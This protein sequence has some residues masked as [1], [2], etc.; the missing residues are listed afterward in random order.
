MA[1][2][3]FVHQNFPGQFT[4]VTRALAQRGDTVVGITE[5]KRVKQL[6]TIPNLRVRR[7]EWQ[8][9]RC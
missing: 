1:S 4:H 9:R 5:A 6:P 7:L 2:Y 3:L 8:L